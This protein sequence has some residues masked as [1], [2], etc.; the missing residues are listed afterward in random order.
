M[1]VK[2]IYKIISELIGAFSIFAAGLIFIL[3]TD[4]K[5]KI[6]STWL[7]VAIILS[8]ASGIFSLVA[9]TKKE[10]LSFFFSFK[11]VGAGLNIGFIIYLIVYKFS[12]TFPKSQALS[13]TGNFVF[14]FC[15]ILSIIAIISQIV[16][17]IFNILNQEDLGA[18][19]PDTSKENG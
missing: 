10:N 17:I 5:L 8:F 16:N 2:S 11:G 1:K 9:N 15:L 4:V 3:I 18:I 6:S 13:P 7:F 19:G 12:S 14:I